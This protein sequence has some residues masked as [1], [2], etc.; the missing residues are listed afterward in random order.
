MSGL[1]RLLKIA[2]SRGRVTI[3]YPY[4]KTEIPLELRGKPEIDFNLCIGCGGCANVCPPS[5]IT[6]EDVG[7]RRILRLNYYR[8]IFCG[9]CEENCP[10]GAIRLTNEFEIASLDKKDLTITA[11][12]ELVRCKKCGRPFA[13]RRL[14]ETITNYL[15]SVDISYKE[16]LKEMIWL[17]PE[18]R[19]KECAEILSRSKFFR[20]EEL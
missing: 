16:D 5:A 8:C 15:L 6:I 4:E 17:C 14:I 12:F 2:L 11:E 3:K 19:R 1:L 13:T 20:R 9:R 7:N 10:T 18:C